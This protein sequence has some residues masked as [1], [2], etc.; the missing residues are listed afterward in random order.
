MYWKH[1]WSLF[2]RYGQCWVFSGCLTTA[3]RCLGIASRSVTCIGSLHDFNANLVDDNFYEMAENTRRR[4]KKMSDSTWNFH[5]WNEGWFKR[6]DLG[7]NYSGWQVVDATPQEDS[8]NIKQC[9]P[10]SV[11]AIKE[12]ENS[13]RYGCL[14]MWVAHNLP[15]PL[16][17]IS[18]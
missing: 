4:L 15:S 2:C 16:I 12:G 14:L 10:A 5:V 17:H 8:N 6:P 3:L 9:G 18:A 11:N 7:D 1:V 13:S